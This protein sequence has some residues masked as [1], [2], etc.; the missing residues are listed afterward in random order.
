MPPCTQSF[1]EAIALGRRRGRDFLRVLQS[2]GPLSIGIAGR[3][4]CYTLGL[5][6]GVA[7]SN[8]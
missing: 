3:N 8:V 5:T 2:L 7:L 4:R 1:D 6:I